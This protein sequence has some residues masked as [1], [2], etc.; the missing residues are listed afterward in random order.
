MFS[1]C[2]HP[3]F[4]GGKKGRDT[5]T[6]YRA[7]PW[8]LPLQR[9]SFEEVASVQFEVFRKRERTSRGSLLSLFH[10]KSEIR[11]LRLPSAAQ[12]GEH[13]ETTEKGGGGFGDGFGGEVEVVANHLR[14]T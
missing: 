3:G 5:E 10:S 14:V 9:Q 8:V 2:E 11:N 13:S 1:K 7:L 4:S 6:H 12:Q